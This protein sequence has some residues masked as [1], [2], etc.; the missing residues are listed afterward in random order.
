MN[1][2]IFGAFERHN[3]GDWL[4]AYCAEKLLEKEPNWIFDTKELGPGVNFGCGNFLSLQDY[5]EKESTPVIV[6]VGGQ[7]LGCSTESAIHMNGGVEASSK[8][9]NFYLLPEVVSGRQIT[10]SFFA[11]GGG[12]RASMRQESNYVRSALLGA[13]WL[14]VRESKTAQALKSIGVKPKINPDL[15]SVIR[16]VR[17]KS[18]DSKH[19]GAL[20][21][22]SARYLRANYGDVFDFCLHLL[23]RFKKLKIIAAGVAPGHDSWLY[24]AKLASDLRETSKGEVE[25]MLNLNPL[26]IVDE[27]ASARMV[28]ASSLHV[29][30]VAMAY[31]VPR[32]SLFV[33]KTLVYAQ[34]WD[35]ESFFTNNLDN[36]FDLVE[37]ATNYS[38]S[39]YKNISENLSE[40]TKKSWKEM[41]DATFG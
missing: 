11:I 17:G 34:E 9:P 19:S 37:K 10:R 3:F 38:T 21:Q 1:T 13:S 23:S 33:E 18:L 24:Y 29:R 14:S 15:V 22:L 2:G 28:I 12:I 7:T 8:R 41:T 31:G 32:V 20:F 27:I 16:D 6:H 36:A 40:L 26:V 25:L 39:D 30:I 35:S 4:M 5:L